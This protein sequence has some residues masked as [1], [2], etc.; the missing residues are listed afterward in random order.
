MRKSDLDVVKNIRNKIK[1]NILNY[2]LI[3]NNDKV[4]VAVSGGPDSMCILDCLINLREVFLK[5]YNISYKLVVAHVNHMIR[6]ESKQEKVYV[7]NF[8][9]ENNLEFFYKE[10]DVPNNS[11]KFKMSEETYG[12]KIRYEFFEEVSKKTD[13]QKIVT[14]HN[15]NDDVETI[16]LNMLRGCGLKGLTGMDFICD[17]IIRPMLNI[18][19]KDIL[20]Y[21]EQRNLNPAIDKTNFENIYARNKVRNILIPNLQKDYN[22]NFILS[23]KRMKKILDLDERFIEKYTNDVVKNSIVENN[24][25]V[26]KFNYK[27]IIKQEESIKYRAIREIIKLKLGNLD[28]IENVHIEDILKLLE[29]GIP[30]KKFI[31]GNKF[32]VEIMNKNVAVIF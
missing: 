32:T 29:K 6:E 17:N 16:L 15:L 22:S 3:E 18:E 7:E 31:I 28:G 23:I 14:A 24:N 30:R 13:S 5:K 10:E 25:T 9:K 8:C 20:L 27:N 21:N 26:I 11:K 1:E 4:V 12:R 19:K 2:N